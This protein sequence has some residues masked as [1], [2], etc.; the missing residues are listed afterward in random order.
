MQ[1]WWLS[2]GSISRAQSVHLL[3]LSAMM[4]Y[5]LERQKN[6][7]ALDGG[8][9]KNDKLHRIYKLQQVPAGIYACIFN[10]KKMAR[11]IL[12]V[13]DQM[14]G[15]KSIYWDYVSTIYAIKIYYIS[16]NFNTLSVRIFI[17]LVFY[18]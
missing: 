9:N 10:N 4:K 7:C 1:A 16:Q 5:T 14:V 11:H 2:Q 12:C 3:C 15:H 13:L 6:T 8:Q 17:R 18:E